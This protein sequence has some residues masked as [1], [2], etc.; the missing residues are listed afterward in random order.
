MLTNKELK[1]ILKKNKKIHKQKIS[2]KNRTELLKI[3][4]DYNLLPEK[5]LK[6]IKKKINKKDNKGASFVDSK[7]DRNLR[8]AQKLI[9]KYKNAKGE[10]LKEKLFQKLENTYRK[11]FC[12]GKSRNLYE[13]ELHPFCA[14]FEGPGTKIE[15]ANVKN[16]KPY[17]NIDACAKVHDIEYEDANKI[18]DGGK[19]AK[20]IRQADNKVLECFDKFPKEEP[21][22]SLGKL[23]IKGKITAEKLLPEII[24]KLAPKHYGSD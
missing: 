11:L 14:N 18:Q 2:N 23:G 16:Y 20:A 15:L 10:G 12:N 9:D 5:E 19:K 17:N 1:E 4:I 24:K 8:N 13:G 22:Y 3:I 21:Y 6:K 7:T